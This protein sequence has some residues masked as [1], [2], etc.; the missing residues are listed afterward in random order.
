MYTF[1]TVSHIGNVYIIFGYHF[2]SSVIIY[3]LLQTK[4]IL[5]ISHVR[6][7]CLVVVPHHHNHQC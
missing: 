7:E 4:N 2:I 3:N 6:F 1:A 5:F